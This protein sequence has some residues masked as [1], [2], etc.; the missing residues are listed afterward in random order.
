M[1]H[2][3]LLFLETLKTESRLKL[4][5]FRYRPKVPIIKFYFKFL[6]RYLKRKYRGNLLDRLEQR[7]LLHKILATQTYLKYTA[8]TI[9]KPE[10]KLMKTYLS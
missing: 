4:K 1:R 2:S 10:T 3:Q 5:N 9:E 7:Q 8:K 6:T